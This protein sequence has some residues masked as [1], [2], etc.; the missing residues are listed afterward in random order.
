MKFLRLKG[1]PVKFVRTNRGIRP[2]GRTTL[3]IVYLESMWDYNSLSELV[4][5]ISFVN[6]DHIRRK[7]AIEGFYRSDAN[8]S[9]TIIDMHA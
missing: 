3:V 6:N 9:G 2:S 1:V 5:P 4:V 7:N 8:E